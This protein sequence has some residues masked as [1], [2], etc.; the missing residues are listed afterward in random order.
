[1]SKKPP[2]PPSEP[3]AAKPH[4]AFVEALRGAWRR[5]ARPEQLAP[6]GAWTTWV[7]NGGRG[8]GKTRSGAEWVQERV[9]GG[10]RYVHLVAPTAA[11]VRDVMLEGPAG[12][13]SIAAPHMRPIYQPS[14]RKLVWPNGAQ[15]LLFSADEPDRLRGPQ[16]GTLWIDE[17]CAMRTAQDVLDNAYFGLRLGKDPRC[18][19][20]TT[21]RPLK[22]FKALLARDGQDVV[23]TRSSSYAN[24][25][26]LAPSFF[27]QIVAKYAGTRL[28]AQEVEAQ[29]LTDTPGALWHLD[30]IEELRVRVAPQPFERV[31]VAID[32]AVTFGP[33]S[34]ETGIVVVALAADGTAYVLDDLSG[35][36]PP[37][38]WARRAIQAYRVHA[39]DRIVAEINN[40]GA[41]VESTLRSVD[42]G[43]PYTAVHA[44]RGKLTRAEPVSALYE[45][46]R[47]HHVGVF[48]PLEDQLTSY[49]GSRNGASPD[50][51]DALC[52]AITELMLGEPPGRF[53]RA[54]ALLRTDSAGVPAPVDMPDQVERVFAFAAI[55]ESEAD[56]LGT[57]FF[58]VAPGSPRV[59]VAGWDIQA[60]EQSTLDTYFPA[61]A[62]RLQELAAL[63]GSS[64]LRARL[65]VEPAGLGAVLLEQGQLR[66]YNVA[67]LVDKGLLEK[68]LTARVIEVGNYLAAGGIKLLARAHEETQTFKGVNRNH[69]TAALAAFRLGD[70][71]KKIG[72]LLAAF[73]TGALDVLNTNP[74]LNTWLRLADRWGLT[75]RAPAEG[76]KLANVMAPP[77]AARPAPAAAPP[78]HP[79]VAKLMGPLLYAGCNVAA[80]RRQ[81]EQTLR[82]RCEIAVSIERQ[83]GRH[84]AADALIAEL[85]ATGLTP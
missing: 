30:R 39:A 38:E 24:R 7:F 73:A 14:L 12:I 33:D 68:D 32:P 45:Q 69:L 28:H 81:A 10:E 20:T 48:G 76:G 26:N 51:L 41:L 56:A 72:P 66:R 22:P 63:T 80:I 43:I 36:Y 42:P 82:K 15:G 57:V 40:G 65:I 77:P 59:V 54:E 4:R 79:E 23:V 78:V 62:E 19:I 49:D 34:D 71:D 13:L 5:Q 61:V 16:C 37:E 64:P 25:D 84:A 52:W 70:A 3:P 18:L 27:A 6:P 55:V 1:M 44:S 58:A 11:D 31:V 50:R 8:S 53:I 35:R 74:A 17:L 75:N 67:A 85:A 46:G 60:L 2:Q 83:A 29:L 9:A 21:P 47:V